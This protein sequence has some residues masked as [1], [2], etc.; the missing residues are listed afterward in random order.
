MDQQQLDARL[1]VI[2]AIPFRSRFHLRRPE[3]EYV[4]SRGMATVREHARGFIDARLAPA[5][6]AKDGKQT[7]WG[8]HPVFR[9]QHG[10][11]TCC[12][13]CL[14]INHRIPKG[15]ELT[16]RQREYVVDVICR[17]IEVELG[18]AA[19]STEAPGEPR[20]F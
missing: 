6:P 4:A 19:P 17:W 15:F 18:G 14:Q 2:T 5:R 11:A 8:G 1:A 7:P 3:R 10:T 13:T 20:L 16:P 12:R 9:A